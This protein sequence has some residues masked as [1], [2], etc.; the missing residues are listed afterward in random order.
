MD[1]EESKPVTLGQQTENDR[2]ETRGVWVLGDGTG[3]R[4][5][6]ARDSLV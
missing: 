6:Q 2:A 4:M 5:N 3:Q 1:H